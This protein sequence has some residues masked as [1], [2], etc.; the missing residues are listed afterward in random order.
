MDKLDFTAGGHAS[1]S[2]TAVTIT[3]DL[4]NDQALSELQLTDGKILDIFDRLSWDAFEAEALDVVKCL[5]PTDA[6]VKDF[7][8]GLREVAQR[9]YDILALKRAH[10]EETRQLALRQNAECSEALALHEEC[11][12][13]T[14]KRFFT[15][16]AL[17]SMADAVAD[18]TARS[19]VDF[20]HKTYEPA[21]LA[22]LKDIR[23]MRSAYSPDA[24][25]QAGFETLETVY[26]NRLTAAEER[27]LPG[28]LDQ[29][30][31]ARDI[32]EYR[33]THPVYS[34]RLVTL[35]PPVNPAIES[36]SKRPPEETDAVTKRPR[37]KRRV[38]TLPDCYLKSVS[39]ETYVAVAAR[40]DALVSEAAGRLGV[41]G[42]EEVPCECRPCK[43]SIESQTPGVDHGLR[44]KLTYAYTA[45][46]VDG[47]FTPELSGFYS[48]K[49]NAISQS[50]G[51]KFALEGL[52]AKCHTE[53]LY[54]FG[55]T[56][57]D[58]ADHKHFLFVPEELYTPGASLPEDLFPCMKWCGVCLRRDS[59]RLNGGKLVYR[60]MFG[61]LGYND[62]PPVKT[63][64][65][66]PGLDRPIYDSI[67]YMQR[68]PYVKSDT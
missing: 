37:V 1:S 27:Y 56:D 14:Y 8:N 13:A 29:L 2:T 21:S 24:P 64:E 59:K 66:T 32:L 42:V 63:P 43:K 26:I 30:N 23:E 12:N 47:S 3:D 11:R 62:N 46:K 49:S 45:L 68:A 53:G 41:A 20:I 28:L 39:R 9:R 4:V 54:V 22:A 57:P 58:S 31:S 44:K 15:T 52:F 33:Q 60:L 17:K 55:H 19:R 36:G 7:F 5:L 50:E 34:S 38:E 65:N 10:A 16:D 18:L 48:I 67:Y 51:V 6:L 61:E 35:F 25:E 40:R